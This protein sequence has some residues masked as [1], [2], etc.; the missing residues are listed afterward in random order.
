MVVITITTRDTKKRIRLE[1]KGHAKQAE[2]GQDIVCSAVSILTY[3]VAQLI[4]EMEACGRLSEPP[5]VKMESGNAVIEAVCLDV[6]A[7]IDALK[8]L[9]VIKT[10]YSLLQ[11]RYPEYVKLII[12]EA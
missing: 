2:C 1:V 3:T 8:I 5:T 4:K 12:D 10:G 11:V 7:L 6:F 9:H